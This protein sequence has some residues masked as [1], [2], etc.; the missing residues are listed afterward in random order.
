M[1]KTDGNGIQIGGFE[2]IP[3]SIIGR[4]RKGAK[5]E[6][7]VNHS[8]R[9]LLKANEYLLSNVVIPFD[10]GTFCE[11]DSLLI[12]NKG[13]FCIETKSWRGY[14]RGGNKDVYWTQTYEG[15][16]KIYNKLFNPVMQNQ[17]HCNVIEEKL[18]YKYPVDNIV[19]FSNQI[20]F[21]CIQSKSVF[22]IEDFKKCYS[23]LENDLLTNKQVI[24]VVDK[25]VPFITNVIA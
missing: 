5:G 25:L 16:C 18:D 8:L 22:T 12:S 15:K 14:V 9:L 24:E 23:Y 1:N 2:F 17:H 20:N 21:R 13:I 10:D 6:Q 11:I 3:E 19:I 4:E 7:K